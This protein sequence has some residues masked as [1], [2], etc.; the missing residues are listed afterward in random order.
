MF[1]GLDP[2]FHRIASAFMSINV[3]NLEDDSDNRFTA[4]SG[5]VVEIEGHWLWITADHVFDPKYN[6]LDLIEGNHNFVAT[7]NPITAN[8]SDRLIF[9]YKTANRTRVTEHALK[10]CE[11]LDPE[12][13]DN[14]EFIKIAQNLDV[15][16][17]FLEDY[18]VAHLK[19]IGVR[20]LSGEELFEDR[21]EVL[22]EMC[23]SRSCLAVA[24]IPK[25]SIIRTPTG[26]DQNFKVLAVKSAGIYTPPLCEFIDD[27]PEELHSGSLVGCSGGPIFFTTGTKTVVVAVQYAEEYRSGVRYIKAVGSEAFFRLLQ[28]A[29]SYAKTLEAAEGLEVTAVS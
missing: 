7:L 14:A 16:A 23:K 26:T 18:Y 5:F 11:D 27:F 8:P 19:A 13:P 6:G 24:G 28:K 15:G 12:N 22:E 3:E 29:I 1:P 10:L 17:L 25:N 2:L 4:F 21:E 9:S 20:P